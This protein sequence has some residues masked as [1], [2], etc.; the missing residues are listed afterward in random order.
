MKV[1][2]NLTASGIFFFLC[3]LCGGGEAYSHNHCHSSEKISK[4]SGL[5]EG[6]VVMTGSEPMVMYRI[7]TEDKNY[8]LA[9]E[10]DEDWEII[11]GMVHQKVRIRGVL[12]TDNQLESD[13]VLTVSEINKLKK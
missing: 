1:A 12:N 3:L 9:T 13:G 8:F 5:F 7:V 4:S 6:E 11:K 2:S 10:N